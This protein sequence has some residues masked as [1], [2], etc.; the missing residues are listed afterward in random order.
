MALFCLTEHAQHVTSFLRVGTCHKAR[1]LIL[2]L[3]VFHGT[4]SSKFLVW[5][6]LSSLFFFT[7]ANNV[8]DEALN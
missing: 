7:N 5:S 4:E 8:Q 3:S 1:N 6:Y 2:E